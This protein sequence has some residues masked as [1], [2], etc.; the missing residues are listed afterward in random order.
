M[1]KNSV[2]AWITPCLILLA[3]SPA[4]AGWYEV[5]NFAGVIG[6]LPVHVSLQTYKEIN[7]NEPGQWRVDGSYYYDAH[8][9]AIPL[10]GKR[11][12]NGEVQLCEAAAPVS[13]GESPKV[14]AATP[15]HPVVCPITLKVDGAAASGEW[16]DDKHVFPIALHQTGSLND[17]E[18]GVAKIDGVVEIPIWYHTKTHLLLGV[19]ES[20][21]NCALSMA[22][23]RLVNIKTGQL[24]KEMKFDCGAGTVST[25]IYG[26]VYKADKAGHV[27][28]IFQGGYHGMGDDRD[29]MIEPWAL[30]PIYS[31]V[32]REASVR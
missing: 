7:R 20:S 15:K 14:P 23:L 17:T 22:R 10:Q 21:K 19:Y 29:I 26:N 28:V 12:P 25:P 30:A 32:L 24:D 6:T 31:G 8:R 11:Q 4:H 13:F 18:P 27:T 3:A 16:R 2:L 1:T 5:Q 9:V